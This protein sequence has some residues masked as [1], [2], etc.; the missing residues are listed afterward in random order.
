VTNGL[1]ATQESRIKHSSIRIYISNFYVSNNIRYM[2][3]D[4]RFFECVLA[5]IPSI[6][7]NKILLIDDNL[8]NDIAGGINSGLDSCW[9][10]PHK[11]ENLSEFSPTHEISDLRELLKF[12]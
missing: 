10:N 5:R 9:F 2:K 1:L 12:I 4:I 3:P 7:K 6:E 11:A 8:K